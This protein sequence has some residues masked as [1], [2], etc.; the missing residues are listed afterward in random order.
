MEKSV[1]SAVAFAAR[2]L[3]GGYLIRKDE[4]SLGEKL[5]EGA[6]GAVYRAKCRGASVAGERCWFCFVFVLFCFV[7]FFFFVPQHCSFVFSQSAFQRH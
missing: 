5:G 2:E 6:F 4:I 3:A 1:G 7:F